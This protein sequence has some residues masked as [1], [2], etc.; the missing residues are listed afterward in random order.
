VTPTFLVLRVAEDAIVNVAVTVVSFTTERLVQV[1][2]EPEMVIAVAP[3]SPLPVRVTG[4]LVP[5]PPEAGEIAVN[6]GPNTVNVSAALVPPGFLTV[7]FLAPA[8][9]VLEIVN[10]AVI[11]VEF[12]TLVA[13]TVT[14]DPDTA[15]V[16]PVV[17]K[18][19]PV[20]ITEITVPRTSERGATEVSVG[21]EGLTTVSVKL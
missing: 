21:A 17:V 9:A 16:V 6:V 8:A 1:T 18:L 12:T 10:V 3:V 14:P 7:T 13:L 2:P 15:T 11:V 20:S 19:A 4:T 5:R